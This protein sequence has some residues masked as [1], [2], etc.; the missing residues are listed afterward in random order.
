MTNNEGPARLLVNVAGSRRHWIGLDGGGGIAAAPRARR[1]GHARARTAGRRVVARVATDGSYASARDPR[2]LFGLG[3]DPTPARVRVRWPDGAVEH[4]AGLVV[5][6][7]QTLTR[8]K[9]AK[10]P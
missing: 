8:G 3:D 6:R 2:V 1:R 9:G 4:F 10:S 5:D 7:Y